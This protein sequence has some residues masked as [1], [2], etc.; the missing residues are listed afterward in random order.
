MEYSDIKVSERQ[1]LVKSRGL[2]GW[3][4]LTKNDLREFLIS[5]G[6]K[7]PLT[8]KPKQVPSTSNTNAL[9][10]RIR[11]LQEENRRLRQQQTAPTLPPPLV[12]TTYEPPTPPAPIPKPRTKAKAAK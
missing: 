2:K 11:K 12:P 9:L 4:A 1:E 5:N 8:S 10:K 3:A 7:K 6:V